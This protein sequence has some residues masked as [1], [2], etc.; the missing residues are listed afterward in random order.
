MDVEQLNSIREQLDEWINAFKA[1][2]GRSERVHWYRLHIAGLILEGERKS[3]EP[4][5]KRLPGG[6]E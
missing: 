5:A 1:H 2:L 6:N 4:M 3:I